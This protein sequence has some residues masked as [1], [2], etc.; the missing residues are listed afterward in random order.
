MP[1]I[2]FLHLT[3]LHF[4]TNSN[5]GMARQEWLWPNVR[6]LFFRDL[7]RLHRLT[8]DWD[9]VL[10][11]GDLAQSGTVE[12]YAA[13]DHA[14]LARLWREFDRL[15]CN[16]VLLAVPG[17]HD[18]KWPNQSSGTVR[19]LR[20]WP[21][22]EGLRNLFWANDTNEY[23]QLMRDVFHPYTDWWERIPYRGPIRIQSGLLPGEF[24]ASYE[25]DGLRLGI[26]GLNSTFLQ[27][28][29]G[30]R[31]G[32][33][34]DVDVR[35]LHK[36]C[37]HDIVDWT[38][39]HDINLLMTHHPLSWL[40]PEAQKQFRSELSPTGRFFM[41]LFGHMHEPRSEFKQV[42]GAGMK[43]ELQGAS[44]FGLETWETPEGPH[45]Q[46]IHGYTAG[47]FEYEDGE[48]SLR[49]WPRKLVRSEEG[50][51]IITADVAQILDEQESIL[52]PFG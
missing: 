24:S 30:V 3:D 1:A 12:D 17:N 45:M 40:N 44:L 43:R 6:E 18:L 32:Q 21:N 4:N 48:G 19:A 42:G 35:Q 8:G 22:D 28:G 23:R 29:G 41:H 31:E 14:V 26:V 34:L 51:Q 36:V 13:F 47:K 20:S 33:L 38:K 15:G 49:L 39:E 2:T 50:A 52:V 11:T 10:F 9:L 7:D 25:K 5:I 46:R 16:P 27:L 37:G